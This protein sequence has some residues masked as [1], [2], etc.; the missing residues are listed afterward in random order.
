[1]PQ[2]PAQQRRS[3]CPDEE[4]ESATIKTLAVQA[5]EITSKPDVVFESASHSHFLCLS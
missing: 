2:P 3:L 1:V 5:L 4:L